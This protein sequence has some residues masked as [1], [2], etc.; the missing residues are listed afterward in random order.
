MMKG[1]QSGETGG[2]W[3]CTGIR[4]Q[5]VCKWLGHGHAKGCRPHPRPGQNFKNKAIAPKIHGSVSCNK[6]GSNNVKLQ[7]DKG[8]LTFLYSFYI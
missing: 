6:P 3:T 8:L 4:C 7:T 1:E 5:G 2:T